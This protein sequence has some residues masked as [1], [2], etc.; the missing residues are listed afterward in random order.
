MANSE[1]VIANP[2]LF[3]P[4]NMKI[5]ESKK[6]IKTITIMIYNMSPNVNNEGMLLMNPIL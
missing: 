5:P 6:I 1:P 2:R 4:I 3:T